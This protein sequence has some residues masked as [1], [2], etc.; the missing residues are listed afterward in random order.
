MIAVMLE[1][2]GARVDRDD[3][4]FVLVELNRLVL[5]ETVDA[6]AARVESLVAQLA[7]AGR[8]AGAS[9]GRAAAT[10]AAEAFANAVQQIQEEGRRVQAAT[11]ETFRRE[12]V[13]RKRVTAGARW[14][15][16]VLVAV[17]AASGGF[18]LGWATGPR[19]DPARLLHPGRG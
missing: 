10:Q 1:R 19:F 16:F 5:E 2:V 17:I 3:P 18:G 15:S 13:N 8:S 11:R 7:T 6:L 14:R 9:V 4:A 12:A